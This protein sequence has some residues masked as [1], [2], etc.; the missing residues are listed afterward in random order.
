ML[1][2]MTDLER[3]GSKEFNEIYIIDMKGTHVQVEKRRRKK[4]VV[5]LVMRLGVWN[6][7]IFF[8]EK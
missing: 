5:Y 4:V 6:S 1:W 8:S 2:H 7:S 3:L